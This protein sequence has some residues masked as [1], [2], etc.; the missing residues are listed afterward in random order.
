ME[1]I[2]QFS[3]ATHPT[4]GIQAAGDGYRVW[5]AP[6]DTPSDDGRVIVGEL[7]HRPGRRPIYFS[8]NEG[9]HDDAVLVATFENATTVDVDG[10]SW[11]VSDDV[12]WRD[13]DEAA[14]A[15]SMV[16]SG[17]FRSVSMHLGKA[18]FADVCPNE[19]G[20][21]AEVEPEDIDA[22]V[23]DDGMLIDFKYPC[24]QPLWGAFDAEIAAVTILGVEAF[25]GAR[26]EP[27]TETAADPEPVAAS[28]TPSAQDWKWGEVSGVATIET[29]IDVEVVQASTVDL[30]R[31]PVGWF[32]N[33]DFGKGGEDERLVYDERH[34][35]WGCPLTVTED[36]QVYGHL[37]L[38]RTCHTGYR[39]RCVTPP[40]GADLGSYHQTRIVT[41]DGPIVAT[42]PLVV[43][44]G[45]APPTWST[46]RVTRHYADTTLAAAHVV[47]G[48]DAHG[49]WVAGSVA[50]TATPAMIETL[51]RHSLSGDW[52]TRQGKYELIAAVAV[53]SPGFPVP[54]VLVAAGEPVGIITFG[55]P[56]PDEQPT[57]LGL[58]VMALEQMTKRLDQIAASVIVDGE[59]GTTEG[60]DDCDP[61]TTETDQ[62]VIDLAAE[63]D[64]FLVA[65]D[66][67][68][69]L[70]D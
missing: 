69:A 3:N 38:W 30:E 64:A 41:A 43:D 8:D 66:I 27:D 4:S 44:E 45:H 15:R 2:L 17:E 22:I 54:Q 51:R 11:V 50:H 55:A 35:Q 59:T 52:R 29:V 61:A 7:G 37:A 63:V 58:V 68:E 49:Y 13:T 23:D 12:T 48:E 39:D 65:E 21:Y 62:T 36:G 40:R 32:A 46:D 34:D 14:Q 60:C 20:G 9:M 1:Q 31:P 19:S 16:D 5:F 42:G 47:V 18:R 10:V 70:A 67:D 26:I 53:N 33:P 57:E 25:V 28:T 6:I 24:D 56:H